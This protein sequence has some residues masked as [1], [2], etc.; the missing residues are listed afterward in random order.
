MELDLEGVFERRKISEKKA[1][2]SEKNID[3]LVGFR[4]KEQYKYSMYLFEN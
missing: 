1:K 3:T 4:N 2:I